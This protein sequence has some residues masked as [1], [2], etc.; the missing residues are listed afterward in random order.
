MIDGLLLAV[1]V[2]ETN[3][4]RSSTPGIMIAKPRLL[5]SGLTAPSDIALGATIWTARS[6]SARSS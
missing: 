3:P 1:S 6:L 2:V 4:L 5:G